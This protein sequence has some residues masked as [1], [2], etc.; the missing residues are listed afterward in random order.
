MTR[1]FNLSILPVKSALKPLSRRILQLHNPRRASVEWPAQEDYDIHRVD[2]RVT[3]ERSNRMT[4]RFVAGVLAVA[5][6][7]LGGCG[8]KEGQRVES[9][10]AGGKRIQETKASADGRYT[11]HLRERPDVT[12]KVAKGERI[13]FRRIGNGRVEAYAGDNPAVELERD[14]ARGAYWELDEKSK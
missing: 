14:A 3:T 12:F 11:L 7:A 5:C 1:S 2:N 9:Y 6:L 4:A 13:G 10:D 8:A